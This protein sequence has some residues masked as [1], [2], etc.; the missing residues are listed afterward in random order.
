MNLTCPRCGKPVGSY[1]DSP[2]CP[3]GMPPKPEDK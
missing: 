1:C 3:L 2:D